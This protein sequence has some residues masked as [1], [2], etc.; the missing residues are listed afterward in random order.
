MK[1]E[2]ELKEQVGNLTETGGHIVKVDPIEGTPFQLVSVNE[3]FF[4]SMGKY[5][6]TEYFD[7][8]NLAINEVKNKSWSL[9]LSVC[10][11]IF[12]TAG[13]VSSVK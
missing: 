6:L 9:I 13:N 11:V 8:P 12:E 1:K 7:T 2:N 3:G 5:R 10:S 4:V